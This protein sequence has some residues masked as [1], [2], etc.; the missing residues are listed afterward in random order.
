MSYSNIKNVYGKRFE[1]FSRIYKGDMNQR[2][3]GVTVV[4][5]QVK[6]PT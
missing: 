1:D 3:I 5:Q 4:A 6:N 2:S